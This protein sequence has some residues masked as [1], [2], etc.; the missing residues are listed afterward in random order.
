M[1][2]NIFITNLMEVINMK[3]IYQ[4]LNNLNGHCYIG[5]TNNYQRRFNQHK[6]DLKK[7]KHDNPYLQKA[8]DKYG[9][10]AF[11]FNILYQED[12][13]QD[14][15]N[16]LEEEYI[17]KYDSYENGYNYNR[18]GQQ[19]NGFE[20]KLKQEDINIIC[21]MLEFHKR[22]GTI[23]GNYFDVSNTTIYRIS[24]K[25]SHA[26]LVD[27]YNKLGYLTRE[28][29]Y[30]DFCKENNLKSYISYY[31]CRK[32]TREQA[33]VIYIYDE[34]KYPKRT[35]VA[36]DFN[37]SDDITRKV[38]DKKTCLDYYE[39]YK[40]LSLDEKVTILC[41]YIVKYNRKPPELLESLCKET[42]SSQAFNDLREGP[43]TILK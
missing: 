22:P 19:H 24:H 43:T 34:Y 32:I 14:R 39:V 23:L 21:A 11:S 13:D 3:Y 15:L 31:S 6:N 5:Q 29:I 18:G 7:G 26:D 27:N 8:Y 10:E 41:R 28:K 1:V 12:C 25:Y 35:Y 36:Y 40:K 30:L 38:K 20:S 4:I 37:L 33:F 9:P 17:S 2:K 16:Q 42:I